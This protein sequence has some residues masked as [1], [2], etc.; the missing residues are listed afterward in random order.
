MLLVVRSGRGQ[1]L[2]ILEALAA[3]ATLGAC[4]NTTA[5]AER[6]A[7][8][9]VAAATQTHQLIGIAEHH[10]SPETMA[11]MATLLRHPS[12][13]G[14]VNDIVVEFGNARYQTVV[15]QYIAGGEVPS[16]ALEA[17]WSETTQV[18]GIW[19][20]PIYAAFFA[21]V[22]S[23][24]ASL[25]PEHR[26]RVLLGYPPVDWSTITSPAD[27]DMNDWRDAHF[28]W[29]V[30]REVVQR[31]RRA[32]LFIGGAHLGRRVMFPNSLIHLLDRRHPG[33][34]LVVDLVQPDRADADIANRIREWPE[35]FGVVAKDS[36]LGNVDASRVGMQFSTGT[37]AEN[38]DVAVYLRAGPLSS[39]SPSIDWTSPYG[40]EL[41]RRQALGDAPLR[42][43]RIR[44]VANSTAID[45]ASENA[46]ATVIGVLNKDL[47][48][49]VA[50]KAFSDGH[51]ADGD[52]LST[53]R[54][55]A[56]VS[57]L[58]EAGIAPVRLIPMG[59][60]SLRP[61]WPDDTEDH[62]AANRRAEFTR[63]SPRVGCVPPDTFP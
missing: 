35:G 25:R 11:F 44:F 45:G 53:Q 40:V 18:S 31:N 9:L 48:L 57:R 10:G 49:R 37:V 32:L 47:E 16:G 42:T 54:A 59:C 14:A 52:Q 28:A 60:G 6:P 13:P 3:F 56:L 22:R 15:D 46:L 33:K 61:L 41:R 8:Q 50:V 36:W 17:A 24:N 30:D 38:I 4:G 62:R 63:N 34:T 55:T 19:L 39:V 23:L 51:E 58:V 21:D 20:S 26:F 2:I 27:E 7:V 12:V 43:G 29:V 1:A 5:P